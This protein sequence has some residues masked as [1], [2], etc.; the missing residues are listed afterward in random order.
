MF[1]EE[2]ILSAI[3]QMSQNLKKFNDYYKYKITIK[4]I[5]LTSDSDNN[6]NTLLGK[7]F[8]SKRLYDFESEFIKM[9]TKK[10]IKETYYDSM[11]NF[12]KCFDKIIGKNDKLRDV[13]NQWKQIQTNKHQFNWEHM[14]CLNTQNLNNKDTKKVEHLGSITEI[15]STYI[16]IYNSIFESQENISLKMTNITK[17]QMARMSEKEI[18]EII[19][20]YSYNDPNHLSQSKFIIDIDNISKKI[21]E[22]LCKNSFMIQKLDEDDY[23]KLKFVGDQVSKYIE[24]FYAKIGYSQMTVNQKK[25]ID[26]KFDQILKDEGKYDADMLYEWE[27]ILR[28]VIIN[29]TES[30][31]TSIDRE[32][33]IEDFLDVLF[34][35][36]QNKKVNNI[37]V[38]KLADVIPTYHRIETYIYESSVQNTIDSKY[39]GSDQKIKKQFKKFVKTINDRYRERVS[40]YLKLFVNRFLDTGKL[41]KQ[42]EKKDK[43]SGT[44]ITERQIGQ[45]FKNEYVT[46][47]DFKYISEDNKQ[48]WNDYDMIRNLIQKIEIK[49]EYIIKLIEY[50]DDAK[51]HK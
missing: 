34:D 25:N 47:V 8:I 30:E 32:C 2:D 18:E 14:I 7:E 21:F 38:L 31:S 1:F 43:K 36:N 26:N 40:M 9:K 13:Q 3:E 10:R 4:N 44:P 19:S 20:K 35:E 37:Y 42:L 50:I 23:L 49:C 15:L 28:Q 48:L 29:V 33:Y 5:G 39:K 11:K 51:I 22:S 45:L 24:K 12:A 6:E 27:K 17:S 16:N 41:E 46:I